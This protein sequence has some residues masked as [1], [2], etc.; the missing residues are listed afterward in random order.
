MTIVW[1]GELPWNLG[2]GGGAGGGGM[3]ADSELVSKGS[4][5]LEGTSL[6]AFAAVWLVEGAS[7]L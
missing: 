5:G 3:K 7:A 2:V 4:A 1:F 6:V